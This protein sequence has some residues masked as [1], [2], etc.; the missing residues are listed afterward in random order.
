MTMKLMF[1]S[2]G[3]RE[4]SL[5]L[6]RRKVFPLECRSVVMRWTVR[7]RFVCRD[8]CP[9]SPVLPRRWLQVARALDPCLKQTAPTSTNSLKPRGVTA[10]APSDFLRVPPDS[11]CGRYPLFGLRRQLRDRRIDRGSY[12]QYCGHTTIVSSSQIYRNRPT[13]VNSIPEDE[14]T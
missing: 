11:Y 1:V 2:F 10:D 4:E 6:R 12:P 14:L 8:I 3:R 13:S 9:I 5:E 7:I